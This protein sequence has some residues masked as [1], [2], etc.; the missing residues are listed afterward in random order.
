M[1][2]FNRIYGFI[3]F[4]LIIVSIALFS[5]SIEV[6]ASERSEIYP[7][8]N[9]NLEDIPKPLIPKLVETLGASNSD[10]H[11]SKHKN[12][13][14]ISTPG[15]GITTSFHRDQVVFER[16]H[17]S[18]GMSLVTTNNPLIF[19]K[20][21]NNKVEYI[22]GNLVEWYVN[23]PYGIE[24]GFTLNK[25]PDLKDN[26]T[27]T[28]GLDM[29]EGV[30]AV[31]NENGKSIEFVDSEN[32]HILTYDGLYAFDSRGS[33]LKSYL[34]LN[35]NNSI[36]IVVDD[37]NATYPI[38]IDPFIQAQRVTAADPVSGASDDFGYSVS[39][40]GDRAI[41]GVPSWDGAAGSAQGAA[42]IYER[43]GSGGWV[44]IQTLFSPAPASGGGD[45]GTSVSIS[46]DWA[47]VG[48]PDGDASFT[49]DGSA[50]FFERVGGVWT[51]RQT[52]SHTADNLGEAFGA[53]VSISADRAVVGDN[54]FGVSTTNNQGAI[55][56]YERPGPTWI[57]IGA[58]PIFALDNDRNDEFGASVSISGDWLIAGA[59]G[60]S[61]NGGFTDFISWG[62]VY[63]FQRSGG[64]WVER[65]KV[66]GI[67]DSELGT[68]VA[69]DGARA[70]AGAPGEAVTGVGFG[71]GAVYI[72][73]RS[74]ITW[75]NT[76]LSDN[77]DDTRIEASNPNATDDF[78]ISVSISGD[79]VAIG[80][81]GQDIGL[82][83]QPGTISNAG[84]VYIYE[85]AGLG[86]WGDEQEVLASDPSISALFGQS[87]S[88]SGNTIL[89]GSPQAD[90]EGVSEQGA[91]YFL[92]LGAMLTIE[93]E[94]NPDG[95]TGFVFSGTGFSST[96]GL[97]GSFTLDDNDSAGTSFIDC[98]VL[99]GPYTVQ[100]TDPN[101]H[102]ISDINCVGTQDFTETA[103]SITVNLI[104][105]DMVVCTFT[106]ALQHT[107]TTSIVGNGTI[108]SNPLGIDCGSDCTEDYSDGTVVTLTPIPDPGFVFDNWSGDP[109]C[110]DGSVTMSG[111]R[112]CTANFKELFT[113]TITV[114]GSGTVTSAPLGIDCGSDCTED[115]V[116]GTSITLTAMPE[117]GA[118]F[119][120]WGGD[121]SSAG[122]STTAMVTMNSAQTCTADFTIVQRTLTIIPSGTGT[123]TVTT[124]PAGID[125][126]SDCTE[127]Y[128]DA[129]VVT[130]SNT[131]APDSV[132]AGYTGSGCTTGTVT[133]DDD[134]TCTARFNLKPTLTIVKNG[135]GAGTVTS[136]PPGINCGSD[137]D[138]MFNPG[139][140]VTMNAAPTPGSVFIG[141]TGAGCT[142]GTV[143]V[144]SDTTCTATF[145]LIQQFNLSITKNGTGGG[146]VSSN[147]AG[148]NCGSTCTAPF[149]E[150]TVIT[151][152]PLA[153]IGSEF[154]GWSGNADCADGIVT[155]SGARNC[156][157]TFNL[158]VVPAITLL[159]LDPSQGGVVNTFTITGATPNGQVQI[160]WGFSEEVFAANNIC[161]GFVADIRKPRNLTTVTANGS[162]TAV[163]LLNV[164]NNLVGIAFKIQAVDLIPCEGS[165]VTT[166][167]IDPSSPQNVPV[168]NALQPGAVGPNTL[169]STNHTPGGPVAFIWGFIEEPSSGNNL[170]A[171]LQAGIRNFRNLRTGVADQFGNITINVTVPQVNPGTTVKLQTVDL[172]SC[173][174]SNVTTETF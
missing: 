91:G 53:S 160:L 66:I 33:E 48:E 65:Q 23:S 46:G 36:E 1:F 130:L 80:A 58:N 127:D 32:N 72:F 159:P 112:S 154:A 103:D 44:E 49:N 116:M 102:I 59:P 56:I 43:N 18:I 63:F 78:G 168:L 118:T 174:P 132:F 111:D 74:V 137:C 17:N 57:S 92:D 82:P 141:F 98:D 121:C 156:T 133:M 139:T 120:T 69:M 6:R 104:A 125:C 77:T 52:V 22:R 152:S 89:V 45:F 158:E 31:Y 25:K 147:P 167:T 10:Y 29:S 163:F 41:V 148:V 157:A 4:L 61:N 84:S 140:V 161:P 170:C 50:H 138:A 110:S 9:S 11:I 38:I 119:V 60:D 151:L 128:D 47:L 109:D 171:G 67:D 37:K 83:A 34:N 55:F 172:L 101:G 86:N 20:A 24:Q 105:D 27:I 39:I 76:T 108:G 54:L 99:P 73:E 3:S 131:P 40:D 28:L 126:G 30:K 97:D 7:F 124:T 95:G 68:S 162:G 145:N 16:G 79:H 115:Y 166:E 5:I 173:T 117:V 114:N 64:T 88:I 51:F 129:T 21:S 136:A 90:E 153:D 134:K 96:C 122:N 144:N 12:V 100:E 143:T 8:Y 113:L 165:N 164:P 13:Y 169:I 70:V 62:A 93:K 15:H 107:L 42:I 142:T 26:I 71:A 150:N 155:M 123:G 85:R 94:S 87:V 35:Q 146:N 75:G 14:K 19:Q 2:K 149:N 135:S 81:T 106:N